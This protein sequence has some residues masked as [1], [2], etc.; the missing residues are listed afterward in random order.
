MLESG[1]RPVPMDLTDPVLDHEILSQG[2]AEPHRP[3]W[4][5]VPL[6]HTT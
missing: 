3:Q 2:D 1:F 4:W 5:T 6:V